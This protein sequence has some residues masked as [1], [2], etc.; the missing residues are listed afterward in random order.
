MIKNP[1]QGFLWEAGQ[2]GWERGHGRGTGLRRGWAGGVRAIILMS[3]TLYHPYTQVKCFSSPWSHGCT[4]WCH[5]KT[6]VCV[7]VCVCVCSNSRNDVPRLTQRYGTIAAH[8]RRRASVLV[9]FVVFCLHMHS[10]ARLIRR[11]PPPT[12]SDTAI[13]DRHSDTTIFQLRA[14]WVRISWSTGLEN[15]SDM[16]PRWESTPRLPAC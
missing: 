1:N 5:S 14:H 16:C 12:F 6:K 13:I 11:T 15:R 8:T 9:V 7:C 3:D 2:V 10:F 4:P